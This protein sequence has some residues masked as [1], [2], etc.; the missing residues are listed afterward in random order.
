MSKKKKQADG[1]DQIRKTPGLS[2]SLAKHLNISKQAVS[3]WKKVPIGRLADVEDFTGIP[4]ERLRPDL[5]AR[6]R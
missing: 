1:L 5:F 3:D 4:R 6:R 2:A